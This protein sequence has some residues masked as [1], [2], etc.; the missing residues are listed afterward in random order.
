[1]TPERLQAIQDI[2]REALRNLDALSFL[3]KEHAPFEQ[4]MSG[5]QE[6]VD[7]IAKKYALYVADID[8]QHGDEV[9]AAI[10]K[11]AIQKRFGEEIAQV[12]VLIDSVQ[13]QSYGSST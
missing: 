5:Y 11:T 2:E 3:A 13:E 10:Q 9:T 12:A 6:L 7:C 4:I 1:M 8:E